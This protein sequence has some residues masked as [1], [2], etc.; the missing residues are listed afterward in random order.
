MNKSLL[1]NQV[2]AALD[3]IY[4]GAVAAA[5]RAHATATN[6]ESVAEN[7]YD[8]FAL[9]ASY[10]AQGQ[11]QRVAQCQADIDAFK[12]LAGT[13]NSD[14]SSVSLGS[15]IAVIDEND[16]RHYFLLGPCAG[17]LKLMFDQ[18]EIICI[19]PSAPIGL[20]LLGKGVDDEFE[21]KIGSH[22]HSYEIIAL[23]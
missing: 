17:G 19:T 9:E 8:T 23:Y 1:L 16:A 13:M 2:L 7:K 20:A 21:I 12:Q 3:D 6:N 18:K 14:L 4:R 22:Q 10:L 15:L 5:N 11:S